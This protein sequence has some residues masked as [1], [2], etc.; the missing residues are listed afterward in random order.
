MQTVL[1]KGEWGLKIEL[2]NILRFLKSGAYDKGLHIDSSSGVYPDSGEGQEKWSQEGGELTQGVLLALANEKGG[3]ILE[4]R[5]RSS[6]S[7]IHT[8][9]LFQDT[10]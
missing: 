8:C 7:H 6:D 10:F 2:G 5:Q 3:L 4:R 1:I 9:F